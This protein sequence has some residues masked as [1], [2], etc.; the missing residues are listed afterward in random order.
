MARYRRVR[1][2]GRSRQRGSQFLVHALASHFVSPF[3]EDVSAQRPSTTSIPERTSS[4]FLSGRLPA[5]SVREALSSVTSCETF[6][7]ESLGSPVAFA[8][9]R[10]LPGASAQRVLLVRAT[11]TTV[12]IRL[13]LNESL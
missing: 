4:S 13:R 10:T 12:A 5:R 9:S 8:E 7:T 6:A 3:H 2:G 11:H 1:I